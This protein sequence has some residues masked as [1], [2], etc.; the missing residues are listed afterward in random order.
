M[1]VWTYYLILLVDREGPN[2]IS[3][4]S[5]RLPE[6]KGSIW[7]L[8]VRMRG[9]RLACCTRQMLEKSLSLIR[10]VSTVD[11]YMHKGTRRRPLGLWGI[12]KVVTPKLDDLSA[13]VA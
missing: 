13:F 5:S 7:S 12:Y 10:K 2:L 1:R 3:S 8:I 9:D 11:L 4:Q 6:M